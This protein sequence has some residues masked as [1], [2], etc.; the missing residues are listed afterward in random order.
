MTLP[1]PKYICRLQ[2]HDPGSCDA[3]R[4]AICGLRGINWDSWW[5]KIAVWMLRHAS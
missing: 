1:H 5:A 2:R 4:D 3:M